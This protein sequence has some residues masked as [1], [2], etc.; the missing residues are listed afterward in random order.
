MGFTDYYA[1]FEIEPTANI[2]EIELAYRRVTLLF[3]ADK[4]HSR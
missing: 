2:R 1:F 3:H 4:N